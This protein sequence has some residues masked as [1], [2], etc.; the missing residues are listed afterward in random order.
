MSEPARDLRTLLRDDDLDQRVV[1]PGVSW[2][3]YEALDALRG[4]R[5]TPRLTYLEGTLELM[6]PGRNHERIA[7]ML[8]RL[9][10]VWAMESGAAVNAYRSWTLK[11]EEARRGAEADN[12]Y[13]VGDGDAEKEVPDLAVEVVW[14]HDDATKLAVYAGLGVREVWVW[15]ASRIAVHVLRGGAYVPAPRSEALPSLDLALLAR[16]AERL[17]QTRAL[18]EYRDALRAATG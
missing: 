16:F 13:T 17:D 5:R 10:A 4:E 7:G 8:D 2:A 12:C 11:R 9:L 15:K 1:L 14:S 6:S 18:C 3:M